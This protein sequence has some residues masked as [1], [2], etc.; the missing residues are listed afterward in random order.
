[1]KIAIL[2]GGPAV[3]TVLA[4][5]PMI[6][7]AEAQA[8]ADPPMGALRALADESTGGPILDVSLFPVQPWLDGPQWPMVYD[9]SMGVRRQD[10]KLREALDGVLERR[11][12]EI[13][14]LLASYGVP[15][16]AEPGA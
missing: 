7:P 5:R 3:G 16:V 9:I 11:A 12:G 1:M 4:K 10:A 8:I 14:Q 13:R 15:T 2:G 6:V